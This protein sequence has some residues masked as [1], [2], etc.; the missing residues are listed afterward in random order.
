MGTRYIQH[1]DLCGC[2]I[3]ARKCDAGIDT[4]TY[5]EVEDPEYLDCG[6]SIWGNCGCAMYEGDY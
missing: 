5:D 1:S 6:C 2:N 4:P 3:C